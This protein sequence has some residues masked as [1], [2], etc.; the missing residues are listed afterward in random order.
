M[1][2]HA[3]YFSL[4][5]VTLVGFAMFAPNNGITGLTVDCEDCGKLCDV[6]DE[7]EGTICCPTTWESGVCHYPES[8]AAI[9][10]V[11]MRQTY[12]EYA[13]PEKPQSIHNIAWKNFGIPVLVIIGLI[14]SVVYFTRR[15]LF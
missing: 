5:V 12:Q 9:A 14:T 13:Y 10:D 1:K 4:L 15:K 3:F 6:D 11:S 8:C 7:C 2:D